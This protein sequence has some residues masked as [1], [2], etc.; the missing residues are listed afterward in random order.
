M[1]D[2]TEIK[3]ELIPYLC[4]DMINIVIEY[5]DVKCEKCQGFRWDCSECHKLWLESWEEHLSS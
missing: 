3:K 5:I 4:D 1:S 2:Y